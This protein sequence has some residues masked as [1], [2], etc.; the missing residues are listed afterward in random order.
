MS[1]IDQAGSQAIGGGQ[2]EGAVYSQRDRFQKPVEAARDDF[3][4]KCAE[5]QALRADLDHGAM[6]SADANIDVEGQL[7]LLQV[8]L[9]GKV[10]VL[11]R[12]LRALEVFR[13]RHG[14]TR[15]PVAVQPLE[16]LLFLLILVFV[17]AGINASFFQNAY[18]AASPFAA[19][20]VSLLISLTN[21][22]ISACAGYFIG[23]WR[24]YGANAADADASQFANRRQRAGQLFVL[25][26]VGIGLF[27][28]TV[29][30]VR[31]QE[32]LETVSH[33]PSG[34]V[35]L[36]TTPEAL[37]LVLLG[38]CLSALA[39]Y[40]GKHAFADPY[41][42]YGKQHRAA[43]R[44][45]DEA[46]DLFEDTSDQIE[47]RFDEAAEA[48]DKAL[49]TQKLAFDKY[50]KTVKACLDAKRTVEHEARAA[51][52]GLRAELAQIA[53]HHYAVRG[54][55]PHASETIPDELVSFERFLDI[56]LPAFAHPPEASDRKAKLAEARSEAL[57]RLSTV[58]QQTFEAETGEI[59]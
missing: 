57:G 31:S 8:L 46:F 36:A 38:P 2:I 59:R 52:S 42:G 14:I 56:D 25:Y 27:H 15:E 43:S 32:D 6:S 18:M 29:G 12:A 40:K 23:R 33:T 28:A 11:L 34:Y 53:A 26:L 9:R 22:T 49:K 13:L 58:F 5:A 51:E 17:E 16:S 39:Y 50:N 21:I 37:F 35:E 54:Q 1:A 24:E 30:L 41:P 45:Q 4:E 55:S 48:L 44:I 3:D 19:L 20:L 10:K 47:E 7:A